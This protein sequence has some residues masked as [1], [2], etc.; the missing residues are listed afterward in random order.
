MLFFVYMGF[1]F[2]PI[3]GIIFCLNLVSIIKKI[4][5]DEKTAK[6]TF[7]LTISFIWII[8]TIMIFPSLK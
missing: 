7:W 5:Q 1:Y 8:W 6:N 2:M 3:L 4:K